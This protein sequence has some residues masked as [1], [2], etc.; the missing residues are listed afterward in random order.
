MEAELL[1]FELRRGYNAWIIIAIVAL[2]VVLG[3][4]NNLRVREEQRV[5]WSGCSAPVEE[6]DE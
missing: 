6:V 4:L 2:A 5:P 3:V 1:D